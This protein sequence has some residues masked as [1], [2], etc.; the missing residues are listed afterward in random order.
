MKSL[1]VASTREDA[2]KTSLIIGLAKALE[3]RFGYT[4]PLGDRFLY[5]KKRLW[6]YDAAL[7]TR[8]FELSEEPESIS[9]GFDHSKLRYMYDRTSVFEALA[10]MLN[11]VGR[12]RDAVFIE[13]GK[14][15]SYGASVHLDPL[16]ISQ[17]TGTP[18]VIVAGGGEDEIADDLAFIKRFVT[19]DEATVAGVIVNKVVHLD[20]FRETHLPEIEAIGVDVF[21]VVPYV[22]ELSTLSVSTVAEKLFARVIAGEDGLSRTIRNVV[23]GAMSVSAAMGDPRINAPDK[24]VIS[25]GDRSDMILAML[26]AGGTSGIVLTNNIVPPS[27]VVAK[28]SELGVPLLLVPKGTYETALQVETIHPLITADDQDKIERL[29]ALAAEYVDL[30][31]LA[32]L[33]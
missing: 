19:S 16:T 21:G 27:S 30:E 33:L 29:A 23:V 3:R 17:Q 31:K 1:I 24:L 15:L 22:S 6:D 13:C 18:V 9:L 26:D 7:L 25:S 32:P 11:D 20:D 14:D 10:R 5:R 8:L 2:G 28:A 4:K 12:D